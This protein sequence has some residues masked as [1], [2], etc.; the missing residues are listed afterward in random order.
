MEVDLC[1]MCITWSDAANEQID[2]YN[3]VQ[4]GSTLTPDTW[5]GSGLQDAQ[6]MIG[7]KNTSAEDGWHGYL[8]HVT[9]WK[10]PLTAAQ[11]LQLATV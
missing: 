11:I 7:S 5:N 8:A 10:T 6:T 1:H 3:G 9:I 4:D 2:Y